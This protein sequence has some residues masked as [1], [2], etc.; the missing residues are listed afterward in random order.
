M[1]CARVRPPKGANLGADAQS[2]CVPDKRWQQRV[3]AFGGLTLRAGGSQ[4]AGG[5]C[6]PGPDASPGGGLRLLPRPEFPRRGRN[7]LLHSL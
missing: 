4:G 1:A 7:P 3:G 2:C 5:R 6:S